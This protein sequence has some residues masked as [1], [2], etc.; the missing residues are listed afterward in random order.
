M[1]TRFVWVDVRQLLLFP[2]AAKR[3]PRVRRVLVPEVGPRHVAMTLHRLLKER[4]FWGVLISRVRDRRGKP[5]DLLLWISE[6]EA[7]C[8]WL[9]SHIE[10]LQEAQDQHAA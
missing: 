10:R 9:E 7:R 6:V 2:E 8:R 5:A 1:A 3:R 4:A